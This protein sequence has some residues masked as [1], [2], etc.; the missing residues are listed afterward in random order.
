MPP[1]TALLAYGEESL[2]MIVM[3]RALWHLSYRGMHD[4]PL[5]WPT[6]TLACRDDRLRI[7]CPS[8]QCERT[9]AN[10]PPP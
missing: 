10:G 7:L 2:Q 3:L 9:T 4:W 6:L 5:V 8:Q 1:H